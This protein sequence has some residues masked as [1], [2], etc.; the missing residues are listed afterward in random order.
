MAATDFR[1]A[2]PRRAVLQK[3]PAGAVRGQPGAAHQRDRAP[4]EDGWATLR[5]TL[6]IGMLVLR[7]VELAI[8]VA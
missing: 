6:E 1:K 5:T 4:S 8:L 7:V 2:A 3:L